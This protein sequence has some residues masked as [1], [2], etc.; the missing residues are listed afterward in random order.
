VLDVHKDPRGILSYKVGIRSLDGSGSQVR[1]IS[2]ANGAH[3]FD[4][5]YEKCTFVVENTGTAKADSIEAKQD[6]IADYSGHDIFRL[7]AN[8]NDPQWSVQ[9]QSA[10]IAVKTGGS[11]PVD[12]YVSH[13]GKAAHSTVTL[14]AQS[15]SDPTKK[16]AAR[17]KIGD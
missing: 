7:V 4:G 5:Q 12:V 2:I 3:S 1:G 10:L 16:S 6:P 8:A 15:E 9:L 17:C 11:A 14:K 13:T